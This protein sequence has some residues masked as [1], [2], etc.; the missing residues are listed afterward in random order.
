M[1]Q[2]F[3][4]AKNM[5]LYRNAEA[6]ARSAGRMF[7]SF[8]EPADGNGAKPVPLTEFI[9]RL[10][11]SR[12]SASP[13]KKE[14]AR[15]GKVSLRDLEKSTRATPLVPAYI[16]RTLRRQLTGL[17]RL[18]LV[19]LALG[20]KVPVLRSRWPT[21]VDYIQPYIS[22]IPSMKLLTLLWLSP[23]QR[24]LELHA[25]GIPILAVR[26]ETLVAD[27]LPALEAI[28]DYCGLPREQV[29]IAAGA[30]AEDSQKDT[31]LARDY[32][33]TRDSG[34]LT[35]DL[36]LQ[37]REILAEH[38][39]TVTPD[40]VAPNSLDVTGALEQRLSAAGGR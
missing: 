31:P 15:G 9:H 38:P 17:K 21:P 32:V 7:Q 30:F 5:F 6:W 25:E 22:A 16:R 26:Y 29:T 39:P 3:P 37:L 20:Q 1:H 4:A 35:P 18:K 11:M 40:F 34:D 14:Q 23:M 19:L 12:L 27:T 13:A 2:A 33:R 28:F 10:D 24:Y 36:L 8:L